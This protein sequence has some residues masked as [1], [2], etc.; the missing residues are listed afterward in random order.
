MRR[1]RSSKGYRDLGMLK[2]LM[3]AVRSIFQTILGRL[4]RP[5]LQY[6]K[7]PLRMSVR[8]LAEAE[9]ELSGR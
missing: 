5:N 7:I 4:F 1:A 9:L 3:L 2:L 6:Q 8:L